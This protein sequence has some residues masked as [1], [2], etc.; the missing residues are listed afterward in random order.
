MVA[1]AVAAWGH[2]RRAKN[3]H[4]KLI[5]VASLQKKSVKTAEINLQS[6][7]PRS[8]SFGVTETHKYQHIGK[9]QLCSELCHFVET[10]EVTR[11]CPKRP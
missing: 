7:F 5:C 8:P 4:C 9:V 1:M 6:L 10:N 11:F 3:I 2:G